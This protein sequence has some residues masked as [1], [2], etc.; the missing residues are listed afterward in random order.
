MVAGRIMTNYNLTTRKVLTPQNT[1]RTRGLCWTATAALLAA[2]SGCATNDEQN[3]VEKQQEATLEETAQ[4]VVFQPRRDAQRIPL[5]DDAVNLEGLPANTRA[6]TKA[7]ALETDLK[8]S[9][10]ALGWTIAEAR[11]NRESAIAVGEVA[12]KLAEKRPDVFVGSVLSEEPT[13]S[14]ELLIK[15]AVSKDVQEIAN[16]SPVPIRL[17]GN[18]PFSQN[19]LIEQVRTLNDQLRGIGYSDVNVAPDITRR[20]RLVATARRTTPNLPS[21]VED[22]RPLLPEAA[23]GAEISIMTEPTGELHGFPWGGALVYNNFAFACTSGWGMGTLSGGTWSASGT[24]TAGHCTSV[25]QIQYPTNGL[26]YNFIFAEQHIGA[27]GDIERHTHYTG[28]ETSD[29]FWSDNTTVR[30]V[31]SVEPAGSISIN[32]IICVYSRQQSLRYCG[33]QVKYT[34]VTAHNAQRLVH[35]DESVTIPGDSGGGW[36]LNNTAY[37]STVGNS[38]VGGVFGDVFSVADYYDDALGADSRVMY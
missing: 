37:G 3:V 20:G 4:P 9:A 2:V 6:E 31:A 15:G 18:Q 25:N 12:M 32:E 19:E 35:M 17:V 21:H 38:V 33:A 10:E 36:S 30:D 11:A 29:D 22:L 13:G 34:N 5:D 8:L 7:E 27:W 28:Q 26:Y 16:K 1:H 14:P 23:R 24:S